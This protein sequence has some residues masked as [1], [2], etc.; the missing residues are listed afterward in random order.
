MSLNVLAEDAL[1]QMIDRF[2]YLFSQLFPSR[3]TPFVL[4][5]NEFGD[6]H[7]PCR[8]IDPL[9]YLNNNN[10]E[11]EDIALF[12]SDFVLYESN[13]Y[14][15]YEPQPWRMRSV[16][17]VLEKRIANCFELSTALCCL[18]LGLGYNAFVVS[19]YV[20]AEVAAM[21]ERNDEMDYNAVLQKYCKI[22]CSVEELVKYGEADDCRFD[23][24]P[25]LI[26]IAVK[27]KTGIRT[28]VKKTI[29]N[30]VEQN[31][32]TVDYRDKGIIEPVVHSWV[33]LMPSKFEARIPCFIESTMTLV[34]HLWL[35]IRFNGSIRPISDKRYKGIEA[36][37]DNMNYWINLQD[38]L[39]A[40]DELS[41]DFAD[42]KSWESILGDPYD[43]IGGC[44]DEWSDNGHLKDKKCS[45][46]MQNHFSEFSYAAYLAHVPWS[47]PF[48]CEKFKQKRPFPNWVK[49]NYFHKSIV[50]R[51]PVN[52]DSR[53]KTLEF[54]RFQDTHYEQKQEEFQL[55]GDRID[56]LKKVHINYQKWTYTEEYKISRD[57]GLRFH[58]IVF[59]SPQDVIDPE[60]IYSPYLPR[61]FVFYPHL[62]QDK[63]IVR[64]CSAYDYR[65]YYEN[66]LD[67]LKS[68]R[69]IF[70][71]FGYD[72]TTKTRPIE[73]I[74][75]ILDHYE[76]S[77]EG[78]KEEIREITYEPCHNK[79]FVTF[80]NPDGLLLP[81]RVITGPPLP[82]DAEQSALGGKKWIY[83]LVY[84]GPDGPQNNVKYWTKDQWR[85]LKGLILY[86][87]DLAIKASMEAELETHAMLDTFI[88]RLQSKSSLAFNDEYKQ[89]T[90]T[91]VK[92][93]IEQS[94][95]NMIRSAVDFNVDPDLLRKQLADERALIAEHIANARGRSDITGSFLLEIDELFKDLEKNY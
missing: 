22:N 35:V 53:C 67:R 65:E 12:V 41:F 85:D 14:F 82:T 74:N 9:T 16:K 23:K 7:Y 52:F 15:A 6:L 51:Y 19:G 46:L 86:K 58:K 21:D 71:H 3:A 88:R 34:P 30:I 50:E 31:H 36:I 79:Y 93:K 57:D 60:I 63:L 72:P 45:D 68:R 29:S 66:R 49:S 59:N 89:R 81:T 32:K 84:M 75:F 2:S 56:R 40:C 80:S 42:V 18:L 13:L 62:R 11:P 47:V 8:Y 38:P 43:V 61:K 17:Y 95:T 55:F 10:Y 33:L 90:E 1:K 78:A 27:P 54:T 94:A 64:F 20:S 25:Y 5:K 76:P 48:D 87:A 37:W 92:S 24:D 73:S 4:A 44:L 69:I 77:S 91:F 70:N 83:Q 39:I 28:S 26:D